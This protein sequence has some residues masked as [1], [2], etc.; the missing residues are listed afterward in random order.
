MVTQNSY[1]TIFTTEVSTTNKIIDI[2]KPYIRKISIVIIVWDIYLY[3]Q[4]DSNCFSDMG[5]TMNY[6]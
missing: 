5:Q 3:M 6:M 2:I 4:N 1:K